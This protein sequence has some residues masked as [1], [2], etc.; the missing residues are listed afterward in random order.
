[1]VVSTKSYHCRCLRRASK[2]YCVRLVDVGLE[3]LWRNEIDLVVYLPVWRMPGR[4]YG[5]FVW[6]CLPG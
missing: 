4:C 6:V 1:M 3:P 5:R 2:R